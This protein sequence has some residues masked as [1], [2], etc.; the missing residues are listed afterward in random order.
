MSMQI[1][2][3]D[4]NITDPTYVQ[5]QLKLAFPDYCNAS[6]TYYNYS[7]ARPRPDPVPELLRCQRRLRARL[8]A[9]GP[10]RFSFFPPGS[11]PTYLTVDAPIARHSPHA[12]PPLP[13]FHHPAPTRVYDNAF[14]SGFY[15][16]PEYSTYDSQ[17]LW[18]YTFFQQRTWERQCPVR[19]ARAL[20]RGRAR[21][22]PNERAPH[23]L[24]RPP[25]RSLRTHTSR[26]SW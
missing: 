20:S 19:L 10:R 15:T 4:S 22:T 7:S 1:I 6:L 24:L 18:V 2:A 26:P 5:G 21:P 23:L 25:H 17:H 9:P 12:D 11:F 8:A 3:S 16:V 14:C 13:S